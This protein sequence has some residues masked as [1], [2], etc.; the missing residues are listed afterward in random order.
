MRSQIVHEPGNISD[1]IKYE[2]FNRSYSREAVIIAAGAG[3]LKI[4]SVLGRLNAAGKYKLHVNGGDKD[5]TQTASAVLITPV[6]ATDED[7]E[8][9]AVV[10]HAEVSIQGLVFD[11]SVDNAA[12]RNSAIADLAAAGIIVRSGA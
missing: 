5:G 3:D 9:V 1:V 8:A 11:A 12:K 7:R 2:A 6:N 4:G 10:R